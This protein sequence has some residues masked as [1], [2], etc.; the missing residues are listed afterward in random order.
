M[1][2]EYDDELFSFEDE[3]LTAEDPHHTPTWRV[4]I[5]DDDKDVHQSTGFGPASPEPP[6]MAE[7][8]E[9]LAEEAAP[10]YAQLTPRALTLD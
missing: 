5:V 10:W 8:F 6:R 1:S 9:A 3:V 2:R 7:H 4:L